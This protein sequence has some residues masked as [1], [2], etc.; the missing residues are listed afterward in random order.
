MILTNDQI[1]T[2]AN[3]LMQEF[4]NNNNIQLPIK[5]NFYLIKN[6]N[7]L[8]KLAQE[9]EQSRNMILN[10]YGK[11]SEDGTQY[12]ISQENTEIAQKELNDLFE[13]TQEVK[14]YQFPLTA[15]NDMDALTIQQM[16]AIMFMIEEE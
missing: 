10:K 11:P 12:F 6:K 2:F 15:F 14:I 1:Y 13:L 5:V 9:I 7:L 8:I 4:N 16:E 3:N